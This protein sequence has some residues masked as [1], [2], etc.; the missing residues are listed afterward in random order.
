[1]K[2]MKQLVQIFTLKQRI[3]PA[4]LQ[5][6]EWRQSQPWWKGGKKNECELYQRDLIK[7]ITGKDCHK[8]TERINMDTNTLTHES[9][10]MKRFDAFDWTEDFDGKQVYSSY[11]LYYNFKM[12]IGTGGGQTR[13]LREVAHF[14]RAQLD[15]NIHHLDN[16]KYF[17]N[18]LDG[19]ESC[20]LYDKY[21]YIVN[22]THYKHVKSFI[23]IGDTRGFITW[24]HQVNVQ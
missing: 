20:K 17:V 22:K 6:K 21:T 16:I 11:P 15:Y 1:M 19:D 3:T 12:V 13:S 2:S 4:S 5:T 23:Y 18:I 9:S 24:F 8:T 14:I 10:P 7:D